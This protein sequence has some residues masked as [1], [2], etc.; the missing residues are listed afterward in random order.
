MDTKTIAKA[1]VATFHLALFVVILSLPWPTNDKI[2]LLAVMGVFSFF[3]HAIVGSFAADK[4]AEKQG[5]VKVVTTIDEKAHKI[6]ITYY[7]E[8]DS[9][10]K[11]EEFHLDT[12]YLSKFKKVIAS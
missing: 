4:E 10:Y 1:V 12:N 11:R 5:A 3:S 6:I 2:F 9:Q 8:D 7:D